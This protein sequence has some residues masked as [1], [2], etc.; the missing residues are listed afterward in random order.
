MPCSPVHVPPIAIARMR[1]AFRQSLRFRALV[2]VAGIEQHDQVEIAVAHVA[3]DRCDETARLDVRLGLENAV[4]EARDR[5]ARIGRESL[6]ARDAGPSPRN[7][8][9]VAPSRG[10]SGPRAS[11]PTRTRCRRCSSA[12]ACICDACSATLV[13]L[14]WNSKNSV[15]FSANPSSFEYRMHASHLH[16]VEELDPRD[17]DA[18]LHRRDHSSTSRS[19]GPGTGRP[20]R[21]S[22]LECRRAEAGSR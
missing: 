11:S 18:A 20:P 16:V 2:R 14:P 17:R 6:R 7:T 21:Q 22:P 1:H 13:S 4:G 19:R 3:D 5:H 12:I 8:P 9:R 10:A 15:G